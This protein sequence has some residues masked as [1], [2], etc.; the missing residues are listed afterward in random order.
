MTSKQIIDWAV[1]HSRGSHLII[2][3]QE[4]IKNPKKITE[5]FGIKKCKG[6]F[7]T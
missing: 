4:I 5:W 6:I 1:E 7:V 2:S 3:S